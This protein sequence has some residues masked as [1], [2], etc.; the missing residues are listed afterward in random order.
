MNKELKKIH[1]VLK[2]VEKYNLTV[3]VIYSA[4]RAMKENS[5][6]TIEQAITIGRMEWDV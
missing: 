1:E 6:L 2:D 3:E 5:D 4:L